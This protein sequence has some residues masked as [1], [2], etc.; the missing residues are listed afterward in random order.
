M[1]EAQAAD[2]RLS[3][4]A[5][6]WYLRDHLDPATPQDLTAAMQHVSEVALDLGQGY[7]AGAQ[8]KDPA[9]AELIKEGNSAFKHALD[10]CK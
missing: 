7:L 6:G 5:G 9:Q 3:I 4:I 2:S 1:A 10:L 8:N